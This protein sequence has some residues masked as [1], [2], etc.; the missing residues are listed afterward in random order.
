ME[1]IIFTG[2]QASGKSSFYKQIFFDSHL[3]I[4]LDFLKTRN[5]E[6]KLLE[7]CIKVKLPFVVDNTNPTIAE[8]K[9]YIELAKAAKY[10]IIGYYFQ[11]DIKECLKRN[12]KRLGKQRVPNVGLFATQNRLQIP[13]FDEGFD[14]L[15]YVILK[16]GDFEV[17]EYQ[18]HQ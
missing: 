12:S 11:S 9:V 7:Y 2:L 6:K 4:N 16:D 18:N 5:R 3:R 10:R 1:A 8:R 14:E 15:K 17:T 13:G